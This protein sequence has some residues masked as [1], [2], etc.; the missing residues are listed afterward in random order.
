MYLCEL[1]QHILLYFQMAPTGSIKC[2]I[3]KTYHESVEEL[4]AHYKSDHPTREDKKKFQCKFCDRSFIQTSAMYAHQRRVHRRVEYLRRER[5]PGLQPNADGRFPRE[6]CDHTFA[7]K[8]DMQQH[9][10]T[11][12]GIVRVKRK[13]GKTSV[14]PN[15]EGRFPCELDRYVPAILSAGVSRSLELELF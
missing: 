3:C 2:Q 12:H 9:Q 6:L 10:T 15:E 13:Y 5:I 11:A 1:L 14:Q 8:K 4:N 7:W